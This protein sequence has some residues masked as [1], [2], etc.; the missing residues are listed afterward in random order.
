MCSAG[1][2]DGAW[3]LPGLLSPDAL[4]PRGIREH[5]APDLG[6]VALRGGQRPSL[7]DCHP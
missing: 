1:S 7:T 5:G 3:R 2:K 4:P 6:A